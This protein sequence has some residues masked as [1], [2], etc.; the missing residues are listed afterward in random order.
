MKMLT[1]VCVMEFLET[2]GIAAEY[3]N[4]KLTKY[5]WRLLWIL[6]GFFKEEIMDYITRLE[7]DYIR[8]AEIVK[9]FESAETEAEKSAIR[10]E[11]QNLMQDIKSRGEEYEHIFTLYYSAKERKNKHI[12]ISNLYGKE[13]A[14]IVEM[15]RKFGIEVFTFSSKWGG[16]V[17]RFGGISQGRLRILRNCGNFQ[18][19]QKVYVG[20]IRNGKCYCALYQMR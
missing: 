4:P 14:E 7:L 20:R 11:Y 12:N 17:Y 18:R 9:R 15:L 2:I 8:K 19:L 6:Q 16:M 1:T 10:A 3:L 5:G 13:P